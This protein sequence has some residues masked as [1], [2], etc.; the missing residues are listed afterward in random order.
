MRAFVTGATGFLGRRVVRRLLDRGDQ[1]LAM[2]RESSDTSELEALGAE[3]VRGDLS[4]VD[5]ASWHLAGCD[6][7]Y[8]VGAR[9]VTHG[10]WDLFVAENVTATEKLIEA[11]MR[12]GVERFVHVSSLGIFDIARD[13]VTVTPETDY[14]RA[15][16]LR[17]YYTRSKIQA[18]RIAVRAQKL[19]QPVVIVRPGQIYG[20]DHP[21]EPVFLGR[22]KKFIGSSLLVVVSTGSYHAPLVYVENAADAVVAAGV[23]PGI[24]GR[25]YN[26]IDDDDLTQR[27][28]FAA[29]ATARGRALRVL[30]L[31]VGLFAPAVKVVN[32]LHTILKR[33]G[34]SVAYQLLRSGRDARY[35]NEQARRDLGWEPAV[36]LDEA[37]AASLSGRK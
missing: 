29:L 36:G 31:P 37:L 12:H 19:G 18:D 32:L 27:R 2:A 33:R 16:L 23:A 34:W 3:I 22:V 10:D 6:V 13:G 15:P 25:I 7:V 24:E 8:H 9:V 26:V 20:P 4:D 21:N 35:P 17:G 14:D 1:V 11:A 30:Y 28:Y 5:S